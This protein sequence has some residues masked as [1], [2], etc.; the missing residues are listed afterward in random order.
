MTRP[1]AFFQTTATAGNNAECVIRNAELCNKSFSTAVLIYGVL[2]LFCVINVLVIAVR[3][4]GGHLC[5]AEA[6]TEPAGETAV[7]R[8]AIRFSPPR[9]C[10]AV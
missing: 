5:E 2:K 6:P 1:P 8:A 3:V 10:E 9:H 4:S 7:R